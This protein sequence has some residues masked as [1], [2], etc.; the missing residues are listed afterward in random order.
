MKIISISYII[1]NT[2]LIKKLNAELNMIP[3]CQEKIND[4][5]LMH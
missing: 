1:G 2:H 3:I 5:E 4:L